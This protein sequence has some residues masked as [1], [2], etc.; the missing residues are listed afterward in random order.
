MQSVGAVWVMLQLKGSPALVALV[1]TASSLPVVFF[2]IIGGALADLI[3]R[4]RLLIVTQTLMLMAA[5][6]LAVLDL[7]GHVTPGS[8]LALTFAMGVG[9]ALNGPAWQAIQPELV[10]R[11]EF[12]QAVTLGGAS[13]NLGR[14]LGPALGGLILVV[15]GAWLVFLLNALSFGAVV[16]VLVVWKREAE[17][18]IGPPERFVGAVRAGFRYAL[19]SRELLVVL[20]RVGVFSVAS[21]GLMALMPVYATQ[22]LHLGSGGLGLLLGGFGVG[23]VASAAIL[24]AIRARM[25]EDAVMTIGTLGVAA[26]LLGLALT[27]SMPVAL[28]IVVIGGA[29]WL[30]CVS[31]FN[32]ASQESLPGWVRARGLAMYLTVFFGGVA[33]G[34]AAWGFLA[35]SIGTPATFAWGALAV[36]LT[37]SLAIGWRLHGIGEVDLSPAP[38]H[39]PDMQLTPEDASGPALV[40]IT[41][42]VRPGSEETFQVALRRVGRARR[43]TGA[44]RWGVYRDADRPQRFI[45]TFVAPSWDEHVRQHGRRTAADASVQESLRATLVEGTE[46][47][48]AHFIAPPSPGEGSGLRFLST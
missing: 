3:D 21:G 39:A 47:Q 16:A 14:A 25:N 2:G 20:L 10:S 26:A 42:E 29:A 34:S 28:A 4:R 44:V 1:A 12:P 9:T 6:A 5:G 43:R 46:P 30:L 11:E 18:V 15:S 23:A 38:M 27:R 8:L 45:E 36:A 13:I 35:G 24:P 22:V 37:T 33:L 41:Y 31:T 19:F 32:V 40:M 48:A 17:D 7:W